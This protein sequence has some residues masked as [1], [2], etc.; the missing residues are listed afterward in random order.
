MMLGT[1]IVFVEKKNAT[2]KKQGGSAAN[3]RIRVVN[4]RAVGKKKT[5]SSSKKKKPGKRR[6]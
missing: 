1:N 2:P 5:N 3:I 4:D 6:R